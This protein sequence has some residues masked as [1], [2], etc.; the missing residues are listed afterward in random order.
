MLKTTLLASAMLV[1]APAIAQQAPTDMQP[2]PPSS[3]AQTP[4]QPTLPA[5]PAPGD[6]MSAQQA[7][8]D[9]TPTAQPVTGPDQI[10]QVV[11]A[12]FPTY[13]KDG[14]GTL[15]TAEF[16][17]WMVALRSATDASVT[18][19][20]KSMKAWAKSAFAQADADKSKSI[21]KTELTGFLASNKG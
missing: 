5:A 12:E 4:G 16:G 11:E 13:D 9:A 2:V 15:N 20:S 6:P 3:A 14:N 7:P 18:A 10:A 1:A 21:T 8:A 19:D 17:A